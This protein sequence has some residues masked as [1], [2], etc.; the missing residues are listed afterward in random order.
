MGLHTAPDWNTISYD[1]RPRTDLPFNDFHDAGYTSWLSESSVSQASVSSA[2]EQSV[3]SMQSVS[4]L[5][6]SI[7]GGTLVTTIYTTYSNGD[8]SSFESTTTVLP[9]SP[10]SSVPTQTSPTATLTPTGLY[11]SHSLSSLTPTSSH[12]TSSSFLTP[13]E[14]PQN[15]GASSTPMCV[16]SGMDTQAIAVTTALVLGLGLGFVVWV[17]NPRPLSPHS[18]PTRPTVPR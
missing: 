12:S 6:L 14:V 16:G 5:S 8:S 11:S 15:V 7:S 17:R 18:I 3:K 1:L 4:S 13:T 9:A 10:S 2:S